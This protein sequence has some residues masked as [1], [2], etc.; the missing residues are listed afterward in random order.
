MNAWIMSHAR[1][2]THARARARARTHAHTRTCLHAYRSVLWESWSLNLGWA[3]VRICGKLSG[4]GLSGERA[5]VSFSER[6]FP[7]QT[8]ASL[9]GVRT[10]ARTH[11]HTKTNRNTSPV[12]YACAS[13]CVCVLICVCVCICFLTPTLAH[14]HRIRQGRY[15]LKCGGWYICLGVLQLFW[16]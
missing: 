6:R 7:G 5:L 10:Q 2:R 3:L 15:F 9:P 11:T 4:K 1:A 13:T 12:V 16:A 14:T 8:L